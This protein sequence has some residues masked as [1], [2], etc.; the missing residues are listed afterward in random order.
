MQYTK[1]ADSLAAVNYFKVRL[2]CELFQTAYASV[3]DVT[4][5]ASY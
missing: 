3:S 2:K 1:G 5:R 4:Y